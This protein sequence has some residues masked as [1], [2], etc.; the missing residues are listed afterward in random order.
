MASGFKKAIGT[1]VTTLRN[2]ISYRDRVAY[3]GRPRNVTDHN[4]WNSGA[5]SVSD[6]DFVSLDMTQ[7]ARSRKSDG[8]LPD[9][10]FSRLVAAS[11]MID[12]G[13]NIGLPFNGSAPDLGVFETG[14]SS[15][16]TTV[17]YISS[18]VTNTSSGIIGVTYSAT[19]ANIVPATSC[20]TVRVNSVTRSVS[21]LTISGK[22]V[23][24]TLSSPVAYGDVVTV[25]YTKPSTNP[26][27]CVAATQA[28]TISARA[29][30]N[31]VKLVVVSYKSS[32]IDNAT[33]AVIGVTYSSTLASIIPPVTSYSVKVNSVART[34]NKLAISG[35]NVLITLASPVAYGDIITVAYT[36]PATNPLQ[37]VAGTQAISISAQ[38]VTN[39]VN[40]NGTATYYVA[41]NGNDNNPGTI[42]QPWASWQKGFSSLLPGDILYIRGGTYTTMYGPG[43]GVRISSRSGTSS[44][45]IRVLAYP[46]EKPVLD[47]AS[48][49]AVEGVNYGIFISRSDFW[50]IRGLTVKN[51]REYRNLHRSAGGS[52]TAGWELSNSNDFT[53]DQCIVTGS[54]SGF[55][56]NGTLQNINYINCDAYMNYDY[57]NGGGYANGFSA[58][59]KG[60]STI[61]YRGCR[62]WSNSNDGYNDYGGAGYI[63]YNDCWALRN[64]RDTPTVSNGSDGFKLGPDIS[65][66]E[67]PGNQRSLYN[68]ISANNTLIGFD[69]SMSVSTSMDMVLYNNIAYG[70]SD[71][72]FKFSKSI[73]T[74]ITTLRNNIS[75]KNSLAYEGRSRNVSAYNSWNSGAP[76]ITDAD[77]VSID[78]TQLTRSRKSDG[79]LP[80]VIF[81]T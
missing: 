18:K 3:E 50:Y 46:G 17:S 7:L 54:A 26:L 10:D 42:T 36:K 80:D 64:G 69:E 63:T 44:S 20:Y 23:L 22:D 33:P 71:I 28:A 48:L 57:Y 15:T 70:N 52:P 38:A 37:C 77:F 74:G 66:T 29:V 8:S 5:P 65:G 14:A 53:L 62:S 32:K 25:A 35:T 60:S 43:H 41:T 75:Y 79:S 56:L 58:N 78:M 59:I 73:G 12:A 24:L 21:K 45:R 1:G 27:Q 9:I 16:T 11:K 4:T 39:G 13:V 31:E 51:V 30:T 76:S 55:T 19:L 34:I 2:N 81:Q 72:G 6:A 68:C 49:S 67:L 40:S 61:F 47:C